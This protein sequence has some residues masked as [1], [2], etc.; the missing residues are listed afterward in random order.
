MTRRGRHSVLSWLL[1]LVVLLALVAL[2]GAAGSVAYRQQTTDYTSTSQVL[3]EPRDYSQL[4]LGQSFAGTDPARQV[5][6]ARVAAQSL[7]FEGK[8]ASAAGRTP[9]Q[10]HADLV[11]TVIDGANVL[12]FE[13]H[14][15]SASASRELASTAARSF[16]P[17]YESVLLDGL[18]A[19]AGA[20]DP[21]I[22]R[23][24]ALSQAYERANP[25]VKLLSDASR[26]SRVTRDLRTCVALG[27]A[28][29]LVVWFVLLAWLLRGRNDNLNSNAAPSSSEPYPARRESPGSGSWSREAGAQPGLNEPDGT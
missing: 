11:V 21:D 7:S 26:P 15:A 12:Q 28:A 14:G 24:V 2:G 4:V 23:K 18:G 3:L 29:G 1:R 6:T 5:T 22:A 9:Q 20:A 13:A 19:A 10:V 16:P 25:S 17:Y 8:V 27:G